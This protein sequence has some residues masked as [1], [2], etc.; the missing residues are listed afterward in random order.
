M[1]PRTSK[2]FTIHYLAVIL[3]TPLFS[4]SYFPNPAG[5]FD[6]AT[7]YKRAIQS[8]K[9][10][11]KINFE[12]SGKTC[13]QTLYYSKS[14]SYRAEI[15]CDTESAVFTSSPQMAF[16]LWTLLFSSS[17]KAVLDALQKYDIVKTIS[18]QAPLP[19]FNSG[20]FFLKKKNGHVSKRPETVIYIDKIEYQNFEAAKA[21]A[22][23][24][25]TE[26]SF[27]IKFSSVQSTANYLVMDITNRS[28]RVYSAPAQLKIQDSHG[29]VFTAQF[30]DYIL[31]EKVLRLPRKIKVWEADQF[32]TEAPEK[33]FATFTLQ[34][35]LI[36]PQISKNL[37]SHDG[38]QN[39]SHS[40][41]GKLV[42]LYY[43]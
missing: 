12:D 5:I 26:K 41:M 8:L 23:P 22:L 20:K 29:N 28:E 27:A 33:S 39:I 3:L 40:D 32:E 30:E 43:H 25:K 31:K 17:T 16:S 9:I 7:Q 35:A 38:E 10:K 34:E 19:I 2:L 1:A 13:Y 18:G 36:N 37:F 6:H 4:Y 24:I 42:D 21:E 14:T 11:Y 15:T